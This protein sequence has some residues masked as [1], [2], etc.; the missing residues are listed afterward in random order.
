VVKKLTTT[1]RNKWPR[2]LATPT[3]APASRRLS[4]PA[5]FFSFPTV[6]NVNLFPSGWRHG[7]NNPMNNQ[8]A[9]QTAVDAEMTFQF[10]RKSTS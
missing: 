2:N 6:A 4:G 1:G 9:Y 5:L 8:R 7:N 3:K 10:A